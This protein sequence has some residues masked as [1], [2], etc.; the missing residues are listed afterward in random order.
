MDLEDADRN[1]LLALPDTKMQVRDADISYFLLS[2][3][4]DTNVEEFA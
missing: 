4:Q 1:S 2:N 3:F